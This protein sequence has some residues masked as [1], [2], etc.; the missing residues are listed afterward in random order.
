MGH[1]VEESA[2]CEFHH[3]GTG[4]INADLCPE[5]EVCIGCNWGS[6]SH[7]QRP[8]RYFLVLREPI[9][10]LISEYNYFCLGCSEAGKMC[11]RNKDLQRRNHYVIPYSTCP[12]MPFLDWARA[13]ANP[14]VRQFGTDWPDLDFYSSWEKGFAGRPALTSMDVE[15]AASAL[16]RDNVFMMFT[17]SLDE[18]WLRLASWLNGTIGAALHSLM[19]NAEAEPS[20]DNVHEHSYLPTPSELEAAREIE[21]FDV[22]LFR[23]LLPV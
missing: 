19:A 14:Y 8:C 2:L 5:A 4:F 6:C 1:Q 20:R 15:A 18:S 10:R 13:R 11:N 17:E 3:E 7:L 23:R 9:S 12:D 21:A 16:R 22:E